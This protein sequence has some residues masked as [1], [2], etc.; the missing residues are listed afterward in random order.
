MI[1]LTTDQGKTCSISAVKI[2]AIMDR[3]SGGAFVWLGPNDKH[4]WMVKE[5]VD[6]ILGLLRSAQ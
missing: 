3:P 5:S 2:H 6:E 4:Y 1:K